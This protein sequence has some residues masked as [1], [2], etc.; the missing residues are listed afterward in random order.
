MRG[1][2]QSPKNKFVN[3]KV[4]LLT[5]NFSFQAPKVTFSWLFNIN[6]NLNALSHTLHQLYLCIELS[7][8][9]YV[10]RVYMSLPTPFFRKSVCQVRYFYYDLCA[11][12]QNNIHIYIHSV[13][14]FVKLM[15]FETAYKCFFLQLFA[16]LFSPFSIHAEE[17]K[18]IIWILNP[19]N[20]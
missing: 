14:T 17:E 7:K 5:C 1:S 3:P 19:F 4:N 18:K 11:F 2:Q 16:V 9:G 6:F 8:W 12:I 13:I 20:F 10:E 15:R